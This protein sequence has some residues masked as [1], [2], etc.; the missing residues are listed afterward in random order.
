[1]L[2]HGRYV[3]NLLVDGML[4][5]TWWMDE[6]VLAVRPWG[7]IPRAEVEAEA[8]FVPGAADVRF[9]PALPSRL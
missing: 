1:M 8:A 6:D 4:R 7:E 3:N 2:A 9:E 5:G